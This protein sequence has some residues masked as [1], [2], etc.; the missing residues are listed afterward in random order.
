V[1]KLRTH[2][3]YCGAPLGE[4]EET[5]CSKECQEDHRDLLVD[6]YNEDFHDEPDNIDEPY[7][8][9]DDESDVRPDLF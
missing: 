7:T 4:Q 9:A 2:C 1:S 5:F 8:Y 3:L 6:R